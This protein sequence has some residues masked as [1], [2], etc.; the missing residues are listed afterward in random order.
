MIVARFET[1]RRS[2]GDCG[3][4]GSYPTP[5]RVVLAIRSDTEVQLTVPLGGLAEPWAAPRASLLLGKSMAILGRC[6]VDG[7]GAVTREIVIDPS[8]R[9]LQIHQF[10]QEESS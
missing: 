8:S 10:G 9:S 2:G 7:P 5:T 3:S 1:L 6:G 4:K